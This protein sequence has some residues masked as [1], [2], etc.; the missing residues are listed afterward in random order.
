M[1]V[2]TFSKLVFSCDAE[3]WTYSIPISSIVKYDRSH[4]YFVIH[5]H[6]PHPLYAHFNLPVTQSV[7]FLLCALPLLSS[8]F[9]LLLLLRVESTTTT[10]TIVDYLLR[11][12]HKSKLFG[13]LSYGWVCVVDA[14]KN[15]LSMQ[16][17]ILKDIHERTEKP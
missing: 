11:K 17:S 9:L 7:F 4:K 2:T 8:S 13:L 14:M 5:S 12:L 16:W 3:Y 15:D 6:I 1:N 10:H